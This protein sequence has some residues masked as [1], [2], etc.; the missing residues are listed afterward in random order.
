[1]YLRPEHLQR[2]VLTGDPLAFRAVIDEYQRMVRATC[3]QILSHCPG[4]VDDAV[5]E[6]FL[7]LS[8]SAP[9]IESNLGGWLQACARTTALNR[10]RSARLR[11][12]REIE[13]GAERQTEIDDQQSDSDRQEELRLLDAEVDEL[14]QRERD[15]V[16]AYFYLGHTQQQIADHLGFSQVA[17]QKR[18]KTVLARLRHRCIQRGV[19]VS[20]LLALIPP[21]HALPPT[22]TGLPPGLHELGGSS[23]APLPTH[24]VP[25]LASTPG[26]GAGTGTGAG[27]VSAVSWPAGIGAALVAIGLIGFAA[28]V[29][30]GPAPAPGLQAT[31]PRVAVAALAA[32]GAPPASAAQPLSNQGMVGSPRPGAMAL[33]SPSADFPF[34]PRL[35]GPAWTVLDLDAE[36][37]TLHHAGQDIP[38][39]HLATARHGL[40]GLV[41]IATPHLPNAYAVDFLLHTRAIFCPFSSLWL[42][43]CLQGRD[44]ERH[45]LR[46]LMHNVNAAFAVDSYRQVHC[47]VRITADHRLVEEVHVD[48]QLLR[49]VTVKDA[50]AALDRIALRV[51]D[52]DCDLAQ[53]SLTPLPAATPVIP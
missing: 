43:P 50:P 45:P 52:A 14:P 30:Q 31:A 6:T 3:A 39:W 7:R 53:L 12:R 27:G 23:T 21:E 24:A 10:L 2:F 15:L 47:E 35:G 28:L 32:P 5:Q 11:S 42:E 25:G 49:R 19:S 18:L 20:A 46:E 34:R 29:V 16:I 37:V 17:I 22:S 36:T 9:T 13:A 44:P 48:G 26:A 38:A 8:R 51:I 40:V 1:M 33:A 4:E 41:A